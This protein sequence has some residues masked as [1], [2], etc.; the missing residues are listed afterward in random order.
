LRR[1]PQFAVADRIPDRAPYL[2]HAL[3]YRQRPARRENVESRGVV[4]RVQQLE[5]WLR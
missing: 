4:A 2:R 1:D 5:Q 3:Q